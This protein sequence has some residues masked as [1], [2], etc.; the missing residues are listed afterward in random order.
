MTN[1]AGL[2]YE[3]HKRKGRKGHITLLRGCIK[4]D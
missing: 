1:S 4:G 3:E 2:E